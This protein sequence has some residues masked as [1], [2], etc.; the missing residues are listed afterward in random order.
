MR[1]L[2][3]AAVVALLAACG[4]SSVAACSSFNAE[5]PAGGD[6]G[7]VDD[8]AAPDTSVDRDAVAPD[9]TA[10]DAA[11]AQSVD[12]G[13]SWFC[14]DFDHDPWPG[15]GWG[16]EGDYMG[17]TVGLTDATFLSPPRSLRSLLSDA[18]TGIAA[19]VYPRTY[20]GNFTAL[21]CKVAVQLEV[22]GDDFA[23]FLRVTAKVADAGGD[24]ALGLEMRPL[25]TLL[26]E[27]GTVDNTLAPLPVGGWTVIGVDLKLGEPT[28]ITFNGA[29]QNG[30]SPA[31]DAGASPFV[32][33]TITLG[34][35]RNSGPNG[36]WRV[37]YDDVTCSI[38]P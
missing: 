12:G 15:P 21:H 9:G 3:I 19:G 29:V 18:S 27:Q 22:R 31:S 2:R 25:S 4:G 8:A 33:A 30:S 24:W 14:D 7:G 1:P 6:A 20:L 35:Q 23:S 17:G 34:A 32:S 38:D 36:E 37:D 10:P 11:D 5:S 28:R 13:C 16:S 26:D